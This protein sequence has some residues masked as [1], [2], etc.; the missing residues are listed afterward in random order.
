MAKFLSLI[1]HTGEVPADWA[2]RPAPDPAQF[3][4]PTK[5]DGSRDDPMLGRGHIVHTT[6]Y[7]PDYDAITAATT[8]VVLAYGTESEGLLTQRSTM[9]VADAI[10]VEPTK[11]PSHHG[12][13]LG[14][15]Y[16]QTGDPEAFAAK[17]REALDG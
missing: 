4:L 12:G 5:D 17:L 6:A 1:M 15:E 10:G 11:F 13:F 8:R 16:G 7:E 2:D 3:G 9:A 14:G